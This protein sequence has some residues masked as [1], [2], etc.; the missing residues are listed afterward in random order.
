VTPTREELEEIR[1]ENMR[2]RGIGNVAPAAHVV[3]VTI[4]WKYMVPDNQKYGVIRGRMLLQADYRAAKDT[5]GHIARRAME[6][7][8][9]LGGDLV[10][11]AMLWMP[12]KRRRDATNYAKICQDSLEHIVYEDD[13]QIKRATWINAGI[14]RDAPRCE[15]TVRCK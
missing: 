14:D 1:Q 6:G 13:T 10:W 7:R 4:P 12:D 9:M 5:I 11:E 15:I 3:K 2:L 8:P